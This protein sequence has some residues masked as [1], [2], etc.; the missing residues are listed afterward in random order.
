MSNWRI[1]FGPSITPVF[2][3]WWRI[4]RG[5]TLGV[6]GLACDEAG[7][8]LLVRH[9]YRAGW[10]LPGGG[11]EKGQSA[12]EAAVRE[13]A[14]EGG[15]EAT[16]PPALIGFYSNHAFHPNDHVAL[17]RFDAWRPCP[18]LENGEIAERGF[19]ALDALPADAS[20]GTRRR[21]TEAFEGAPP[22]E[23]W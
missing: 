11:V 2:R 19:F 21:L 6:R 4:H 12:L 9:T 14:E 8:V 15:V 10:Y 16:A 3:A 1:R 20:P 7:R 18:P 5:M 13:M 22:S 17:Y 23:T